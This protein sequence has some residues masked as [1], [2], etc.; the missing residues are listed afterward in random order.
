MDVCVPPIIICVCQ[1]FLHNIQ[2]IL[3]QS[4]ED[5]QRRVRVSKVGQPALE[6]EEEKLKFFVDNG[7][8]VEPIALMFGCSKRTIERCL[9]EYRLSTCNYSVILDAQL[10]ELVQQ[11]CL[12]FPRSGKKLSMDGFE[13]KEYI[14]RGRELENPCIE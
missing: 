1:E 3:I 12:V 4:E 10:D 8:R 7:F 11:I 14:F 5:Q 2:C 13:C 6:I 9:S